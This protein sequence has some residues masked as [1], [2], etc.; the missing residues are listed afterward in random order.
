M[1]MVVKILWMEI[2][3]RASIKM[4][5]LMEKDTINGIKEAIIRVSLFKEWGKEEVNGLIRTEPSIKVIIL[6]F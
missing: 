3:M 2:A 5:S 1:D 4:E 6:V